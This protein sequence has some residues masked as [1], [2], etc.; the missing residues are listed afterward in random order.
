MKHSFW[1][2]I[3]SQ[4]INFFNYKAIPILAL[5]C[6]FILFIIIFNIQNRWFIKKTLIPIQKEDTKKIS[7]DI[8]EETVQGNSMLPLITNGQTIRYN[9]GYYQ[10][11]KVE[12]SDIVIADV[13]AHSGLIIKRVVWIPGDVWSYSGWTIILNGNILKNTA[14]EVYNIQSKMLMLYS[15]SYP[16]IPQD[17]FLILGDQISGT[18][19]ASKFW[20]IS[21]PELVG[22]VIKY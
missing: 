13:A 4:L 2:I 16:I 15:E 8:R 3:K 11:H 14:G 21:L 5:V 6:I 22:K 1:K 12:R 20:L 18:L 19:D 7:E 17:T 9:H 10:D